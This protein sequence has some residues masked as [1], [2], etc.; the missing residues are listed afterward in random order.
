MSN[1]L[2]LIFYPFKHFARPWFYVFFYNH[3]SD[4]DVVHCLESEVYK[5]SSY[6]YALKFA[7]QFKYEPV[8]FRPD[9]FYGH[10]VYL[11]INSKFRAFS[12][13]FSDDFQVLQDVLVDILSLDNLPSE[14]LRIVFVR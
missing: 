14:D 6:T 10:R 13:P 12:F 4:D 9:I 5:F 3:P 2:D 8:I 1:F 11:Y 7:T